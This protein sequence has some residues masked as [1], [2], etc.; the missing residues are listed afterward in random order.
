MTQLHYRVEREVISLAK[1]TTVASSPEAAI[2]HVEA[3][4]AAGVTGA[5]A[6]ELIRVG[7]WK[8][9]PLCP[10]CSQPLFRAPD[11]WLECD[12]FCG[13]SEFDESWAQAK[14]DELTGCTEAQP[15]DEKEQ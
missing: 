7:E 14:N 12:R 6:P 2:A 5:R 10:R 1:H 9:I 3:D 11:D 15:T 8:V 13:W 4:L